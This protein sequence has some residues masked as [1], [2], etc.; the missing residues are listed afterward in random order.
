MNSEYDW[1][2]KFQFFYDKQPLSKDSKHGDSQTWNW[3]LAC[4]HSL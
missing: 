2:V 3:R 4:F 1:K